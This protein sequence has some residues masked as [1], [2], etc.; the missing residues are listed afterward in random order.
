M[1][2]S[3]FVI[4]QFRVPYLA[5]SIQ[6]SGRQHQQLSGSRAREPLNVDHVS[7]KRTH[8]LL[9]GGN[10]FGTYRRARRVVV[11][12][13]SPRQQWRD[14]LQFVENR[15][16]DQFIGDSVLE[17]VP[18][19]IHA[20]VAGDAHPAQVNKLLADSLESQRSEIFRRQHA[21]KLF[22]WTNNGFHD[23]KFTGWLAVFHIVRFSMPEKGEA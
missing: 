14:C 12:W 8:K 17:D 3:G 10:I 1:M 18:N 20:F 9:D 13:S 4:S 5:R 23:V 16:L 15:G 7:N 19:T 11:S 6:Q 22:E 2:M 21:V